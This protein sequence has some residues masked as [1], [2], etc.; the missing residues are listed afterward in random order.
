MLSNNGFD[1][2]NFVVAFNLFA[3]PELRILIMTISHP[4]TIY[5]FLMKACGSLFSMALQ[6]IYLINFRLEPH[7]FQ[8]EPHTQE[9][10]KS[11]YFQ[12]LCSLL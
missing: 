11:N 1:Y 8:K 10:H 6:K 7:G 4:L 12:I 9:V 5:V 3:L 2:G